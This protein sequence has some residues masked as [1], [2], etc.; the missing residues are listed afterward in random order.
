MFGSPLGLPNLWITIFA[1]E[2]LHDDYERKILPDIILA[3]GENA[4]GIIFFDL[5]CRA[6]SRYDTYQLTVEFEN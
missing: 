4:R 6:L 2:K 3:L 1:N 5:R